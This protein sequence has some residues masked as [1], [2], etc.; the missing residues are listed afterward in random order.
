M[1]MLVP[2]PD[3]PLVDV[4]LTPAALPLRTLAISV[5]GFCSISSELTFVTA[6]PSAFS[7]LRYQGP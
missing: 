2:E 4:T 5:S 3:T 6:Y 7:P 1:V